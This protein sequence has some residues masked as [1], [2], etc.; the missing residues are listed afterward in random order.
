M[1]CMSRSIS[2]AENRSPARTQ[3][4]TSVVYVTCITHA[5]HENLYPTYQTLPNDIVAMICPRMNLHVLPRLLHL[6]HNRPR[7]CRVVLELCSGPANSH[8]KGTSPSTI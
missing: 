1:N 4:S 8:Q 6:E 3:P 7:W 5:A 2:S